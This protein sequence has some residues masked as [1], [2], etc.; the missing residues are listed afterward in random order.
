MTIPRVGKKIMT[1]P[2][3]G[4]N[5]C[6]NNNKLRNHT[7]TFATTTASTEYPKQ[8]YETLRTVQAIQ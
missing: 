8:K 2:D 4:N 7:K 6:N 3:R 1:V 5:T